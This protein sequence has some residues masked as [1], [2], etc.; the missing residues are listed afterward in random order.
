[1]ARFLA[2]RLATALGILLVLSIAVYGTLCLALDPL[3][4]LR[5]DTTPAKAQ[6]IAARTALLHLNDPWYERYWLWLTGIFHGDLGRAWAIGQPVS[7][8]LPGAVATSLQL[9][10]TATMVAILIGVVIGIVSAL[11][12]YTAFDYS[13]TFVSFVLY[14]LPVFW[15]A[16]LLKEFM[17][18][19]LNNFL[20]APHVN[21][22]AVIIFSIVG[23]LFWAGAVGGKRRRLAIVFTAAT[24]VT[25]GTAAFILTS[26]WLDNPQIGI[27]GVAVIGLASAYVV[28]VIFAGMKNKR[29]LYSALTTAVIGIAVYYPLQALF[30]DAGLA[31]NWFMLVLL[32]IALGVGIAVGWG[33]GGPDRGVSMRG[34]ALVA[35]IMAVVIFVDQVMQWY[36]AYVAT[37]QIGGRPIA[38]VGSV[39]PNLPAGYWVGALDRF[40]HLLLPSVA[41]I[42][43]SFAA[44]I[45]YERG[46]TLEVLTQD[47]IRT[48]RSKGLPERVVIV[49]HALRNA[50]RPLASVIPVAVVGMLGGAV[51]TETIFGWSGIG[52]MFIDA[53]NQN[54]IDPVMIYVL[55]T[56]SAAMVANIMADI[57]YAL[58]DPRI[59][60]NA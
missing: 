41:L 45:R 13:I 19:G 29:A 21:W 26:G 59:R 50:M 27:L 15:V 5:M 34:G 20:Q 52:K 46:A 49:R 30:G 12:Q 32:L 22:L 33:F 60:V 10:F 2:R 7:A 56:G 9:V 11:R 55:I 43:I 17:A 38:T 4:D 16:V 24:V 23:G 51:I 57:L 44:Y 28:T 6:K 18:I 42:L 37:S 25:F 36:P 58:L 54:E 48:A 31:T 39:T 47:Y 40:T 3:A 35:L 14:S 1:M 8:L 53:L